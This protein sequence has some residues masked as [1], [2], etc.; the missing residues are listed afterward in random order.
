MFVSLIEIDLCFTVPAVQ[1]MYYYM[2]HI[3]RYVRPGSR[4]VMGLVDNA[5]DG[6]QAF[7]SLDENVAGG[8][9]NDLAR[10][11]VELTAW[12]C[13]GSTRQQFHWK[14]KEGQII[15]NGHDW[16]GNPTESCV[17]NT[18]DKSFLGITLTDCN[19][20]DGVG[21]FTI[22]EDDA[23][24]Y[25]KFSRLDGSDD[26][27]L[28]LKRLSNDGGAYGPRGGAQVT[29]GKCDSPA[30]L[31][32]YSKTTNEII[33]KFLPEGPVCMTTGWPF[34]Q[35]G[36]FETPKG[37]SEK[38]VIVLNEAKDSANYVLYD[39]DDLILSGSIPPRTIQTILMDSK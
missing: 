26:N 32:I 1:P 10:Q 5:M 36:A 22:I 7:R 19:S 24:E 9:V 25:V 30:A 33:S 12:P 35:I 16:L 39:G 23:S 14:H 37:D 20:K 31:W 34:L 28:V 3:S 38:T 4:P 8:G 15:V 21:K 13:E 18:A 11:G 29:F 17:S 27:C 2:G 6:F